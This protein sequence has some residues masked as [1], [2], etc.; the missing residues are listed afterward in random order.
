MITDTEYK[1]IKPLNVIDKHGTWFQVEMIAGKEK[2]MRRPF[3]IQELSEGAK[4][5]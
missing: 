3:P 1:I 2:G 5:L 4:L